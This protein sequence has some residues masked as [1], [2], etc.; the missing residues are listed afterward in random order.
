MMKELLVF[1]LV[2]LIYAISPL[3]HYGIPVKSSY[4]SCETSPSGKYRVEFYHPR[5]CPYAYFTYLEPF[6][7]KVY[8]M[9]AKCYVYTSDIDEVAAIFSRITWPEEDKGFLTVSHDIF[10]ISTKIFQ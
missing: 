8:D 4:I 6:F 10:K 5:S 7:I 3:G 2:L 1:L 9:K